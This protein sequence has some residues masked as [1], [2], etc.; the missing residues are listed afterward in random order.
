MGISHCLVFLCIAITVTRPEIQSARH[1]P[2]GGRDG[3]WSGGRNWK[4]QVAPLYRIRIDD[5]EP[6]EELEHENL[7]RN[8]TQLQEHLATLVLTKELGPAMTLICEALERFSS[9]HRHVN[10]PLT[11][12]FMTTSTIK[13]PPRR[14]MLHEQTAHSGKNRPAPRGPPPSRPDPPTAFNGGPRRG[15]RRSGTCACRAPR[16]TA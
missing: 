4:P 7:L 14:N 11:I 3:G 16:S 5:P 8:F 1:R 9:S 15:P 13:C 12:I 6:E 10:A 2:G